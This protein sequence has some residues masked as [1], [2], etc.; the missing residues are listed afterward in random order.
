M[1]DFFTAY[2]ATGIPTDHLYGLPS[3]DGM[4]AG[5]ALGG[6]RFLNAL[7]MRKEL[8]RPGTVKQ[9]IMPSPQ[10]VALG[11]TYGMATYRATVGGRVWQGH[12]GGY[13]GFTGVRLHHPL[14]PLVQASES[15]S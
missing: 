8:L 1:T 13:C 11:D 15:S 12:E 5:T 4:F 14:T 10:A 2:G 3:G 9:M 7:Y 6:A